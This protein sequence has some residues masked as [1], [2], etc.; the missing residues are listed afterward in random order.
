MQ[1]FRCGQLGHQAAEC[2]TPTLKGRSGDPGKARK[3]PQKTPEK[4]RAAYQAVEAL[5]LLQDEEQA[6]IEGKNPQLPYDSDDECPHPAFRGPG[7]SHSP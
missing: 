3:P 6:P 4:S 7:V 2:P 5:Q 1:C